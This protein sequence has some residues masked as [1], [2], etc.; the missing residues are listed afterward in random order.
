M[1]EILMSGEN[2]RFG[3][4]VQGERAGPNPLCDVDL[5]QD[6]D[7][8]VVPTLGSL[9]ENWVLVVPRCNAISFAR[10]PAE[11]RE[12]CR[13]LMRAV[14]DRIRVPETR[15]YFF[16]HG[17]AR[18]NTA[19]G[20]GTDQAHVHVVPL[21]FD[22]IGEAIECEPKIRWHSVDV[23]DP[24]Q[25]L[26]SGSE[27]YLVSDFNQAYVGRPEEKQSQFFRRVIARAIGRTSEW[28]YR[29]APFYENVAKTI[30]NLRRSQSHDLGI[31]KR[32][33]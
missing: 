14:S 7:A 10:V 31:G 29:L 2:H 26:E 1:R 15:V 8:A 21:I 6:Q 3:W 18:P 5:W 11:R 13:H 17:A 23:T 20:C 4:A 30:N 32:A 25:D 12:R 16:E 28:D 9:V 19:M 33:A 22:L 27:Y 24:W